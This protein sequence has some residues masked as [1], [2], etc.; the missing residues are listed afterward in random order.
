[1]KCPCLLRGMLAFF[2]I[3]E[4]KTFPRIKPKVEWY[5]CLIHVLFYERLT[6]SRTLHRTREARSV[7]RQIKTVFD[8]FFFVAVFIWICKSH[9]RWQG[10]KKE[11]KNCQC[12]NLAYSQFIICRITVLIRYDGYCKSTV[13]VCRLLIG[14]DRSMVSL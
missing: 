8:F 6:V 12:N 14:Y 1:M 5:A 9:F 10:H 11:C 2:L 7:I 3:S 4:T 13:G